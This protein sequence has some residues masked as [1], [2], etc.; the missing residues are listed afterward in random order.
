MINNS[1]SWWT[2]LREFL[3]RAFGI[4]IVFVYLLM[5]LGT[6]WILVTSS[7]GNHYTDRPTANK[8]LFATVTPNST[9]QETATPRDDALF[10]YSRGLAYYEK[11]DYDRAI[12]DFSRIIQFE[13]N[14]AY[15]YTA[16]AKAYLS[17]LTLD[18]AIADYDK[19]IE[20]DPNNPET[21][22]ERGVAFYL[23]NDTD[24]AIAD[25]SKAIELD[26]N[27]A[28]AY[29]QRADIYYWKKQ[30]QD[31][32]IADYSKAIEIDPSNYEY[33]FDRGYVYDV[34]GDT[35]R[36]VLDYSKV[37][38]IDPGNWGAYFNRGVAYRK[39]G[40]YDLA[41]NDF[42][43]HL[44]LSP[45]ETVFPRE[46]M[47]TPVVTLSPSTALPS[48]ASAQGYVCD[49]C[50]KGNISYNTGEKI[51][52]F[53]SCEYYEQTKINTDKGERWFSSEIEAQAAGW[54]K[55]MNCP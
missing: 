19:A 42:Q 29:S 50:I 3:E 28:Q 22:R 34:K 16:R 23:N 51:Y 35:Y 4:L 49:Q 7:D 31:R 39:I 26:P 11:R 2:R 1:P 32:A 54:R 13:P 27:N 21:Y 52:H 43:M 38:Q 55:A 14:I 41:D 33:Y 44:K 20:L 37:I 6:I 18:A 5:C 45:G 17:L 8:P 25:Y 46:G 10:Y 30:D 15:V 36:A 12:A 53:P 47:T 24:L 48:T 9:V 40:E